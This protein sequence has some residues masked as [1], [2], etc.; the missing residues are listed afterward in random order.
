MTTP[1]DQTRDPSD[2][3]AAPEE[4]D[5]LSTI[6]QMVSEEAAREVVEHP[7]HLPPEAKS[8]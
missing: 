8:Q 1:D 2:G 5:L 4:D 3:A 6:R 7:G